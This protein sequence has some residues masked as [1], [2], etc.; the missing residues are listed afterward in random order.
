M[1][2]A[3]SA[4]G[5]APVRWHAR[6]GLTRGASAA[7][8]TIVSVGIAANLQPPLLSLRLASHGV[9][10][11]TI[12]MLVA[13]T[14]L[15]SLCTSPFAARMAARF[16]TANVI[17]AATPVSAA[18]MPLGWI[19][20][21]VRMLF[22]VFF[23]NGVV[24]AL[25]FILA[26]FWINAVTPEH[27]RGFVTGLYATLLSIGFAMGPGIIA[28][29]GTDSVRPFL[30][31]SI[32]MALSAIPAVAARKSAPDFH[33]APNRAFLSFIF[34]VPTATLGV[35]AFAI[36]ESGGF[37]FL[38]LWGTH[39]GYAVPFAALLASAMTL[40]NVALQIP[41]GVLADRFDRQRVM[42]GCALVG[43]AGMAL[44]WACSGNPLAL[45]VIVS[46]WGGATAGLY[47]VGLSGL[48]SRFTGGDLAG[49]NA[50]FVFC[51]SLGMLAGP[52]AIGDAMTRAP[53][54]GFPLVLGSVF[55]AY[56]VILGW[57]MVK[58]RLARGR[59]PR[60]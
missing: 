30:V 48:A 42:L 23:A 57:P 15:A 26:E 17:A 59:P 14:A 51:Y 11:R 22:P 10:E 5:S 29:F 60:A 33:E 43:G 9:S 44:A 25:C 54:Y 56:T 8:A 16:G 45:V 32:L 52:L 3:P 13:T 35:F 47:T 7:I 58:G 27:R 1:S 34:A 4:L 55:A 40:G 18:L 41:L 19:A 20:P 24:L 36:A 50:A 38:P 28:L 49:A 12:G 21:D 37:A 39:L 2:R 31:G 53:A 46:I 6:L